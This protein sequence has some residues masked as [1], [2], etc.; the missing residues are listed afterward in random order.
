MCE[1]LQRKEQL[2]PLLRQ[3]WSPRSFDPTL[4]LSPQQIELLF[5]A[6]RWAP[7]SYNEQPWRYWY[8][9]RGESGFTDL[10]D[11]LVPANHAWAYRAS[12]L[13]LSAAQTH[14][15]HNGKPNKHAWYDTGQANFALTVQAA[16]M[17]LH[18]HQMGGFSSE[19]ACQR[20]QLPPQVVPVVMIAVG[21]KG[22]PQILDVEL[23]KLETPQKTRLPL[24]AIVTHWQGEKSL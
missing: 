24:E 10:L 20:L 6:A 1:H 14:F 11:L 13:I 16:A 18:V 15:K 7:S 3:R 12:L 8:A 2:H 22:D 21:Y 5:E 17:G 23:R 4:P 19:R 9:A